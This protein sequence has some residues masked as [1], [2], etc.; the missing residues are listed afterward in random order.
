M[1]HRGLLL[2]LFA[3]LQLALQAALPVQALEGDALRAAFV[4]RFAQFT[5]WPSLP[6]GGPVVCSGP[7]GR[8]ALASLG[9]RRW[10][11]QPLRVRELE[12]PREAALA[13]QVLLL[14]QADAQTLR[15]WVQAVEDLPVLV[16]GTSP[17]ALRAGVTIALIAEPQGM[18]FSVNHSEAKR[19]G[20]QLSAQLLKLAREV[21]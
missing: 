15:R 9:Q 16:V 13:C 3:A 19:R 14:T 11:G 21:R 20:L 1:T 10:A 6:E 18:A 4:F 5:Q 8:E 17:E 2:A 12:T 7:G